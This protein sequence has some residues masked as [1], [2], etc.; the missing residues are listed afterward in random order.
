MITLALFFC[1]FG[2]FILLTQ[3]FL[4]YI[5][6]TIGDLEGQ[7]RPATSEMPVHRDQ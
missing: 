4:A 2:S 6:N 5:T 1:E 7:E 3:F